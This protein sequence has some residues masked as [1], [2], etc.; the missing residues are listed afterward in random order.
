M[1]ENKLYEV[2]FKANVLIHND[3]DGC[4]GFLSELM[5]DKIESGKRKNIF[6]VQLS[7][8]IFCAFLIEARVNFVGSKALND[9]W[10]E[11][12]SFGEK[13]K[14]L[15]TVLK[16]NLDKGSRPLQSI[17]NVM[18][19]RNKIAHGK[20]KEV[21][22]SFQSQSEPSIWDTHRHGWEDEVS[23]D[24]VRRYIEDIDEIWNQMLAAADIPYFE[25][26]TR[27]SH[28]VIVK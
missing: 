24:N 13:L 17:H 14:L 23:P 19:L 1:E 12:A 18:K 3:L 10:P 7:C 16:L 27:G 8:V 25:T 11:M 5:N 6:H 20:P 21:E 22:A 2:S 9:G 4:V 15:L 28:S 26:L